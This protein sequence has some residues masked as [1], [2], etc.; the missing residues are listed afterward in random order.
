VGSVIGG[1]IG[2]AFKKPAPGARF[3]PAAFVMSIIGAIVVLV[4]G[5]MIR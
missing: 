2:R 4:L 5:R 3:H 1:L